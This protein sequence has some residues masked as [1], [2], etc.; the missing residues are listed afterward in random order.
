MNL[1]ETIRTIYMWLD[2]R[3]GDSEAKVTIVFS[4]T[5]K[6][7]PI[8]DEVFPAKP[9]NKKYCSLACKSTARSRR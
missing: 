1:I 6:V 9:H 4:A 7:C 3:F 5:H 2:G 8:C